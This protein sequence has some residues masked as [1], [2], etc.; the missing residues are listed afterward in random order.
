MKSLKDKLVEAKDQA[1]EQAEKLKDT[2]SEKTADI[3]DE[4]K[5]ADLA[6][7]AGKLKEKAMEKAKDIGDASI[8]AGK[9]A[10][11]MAEDKVKSVSDQVTSQFEE[12]KKAEEEKKRLAEEKKKQKKSHRILQKK[13]KQKKRLQ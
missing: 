7:Q 4:I 1:M 13:Q 12:K 6:G 2:I 8:K 10:I 3:T 5:S 9:S 11:D